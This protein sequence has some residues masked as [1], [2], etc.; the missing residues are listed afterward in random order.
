[1]HIVFPKT[2]FK[3]AIQNLDAA[4]NIYYSFD[5]EGPT[6][7]IQAGLEYETVNAAKH[8]YIEA[9][10]ASNFLV[11]VVTHNETYTVV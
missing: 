9:D 6:N 11:N 10:T 4:N 7:E 5:Q 2:T 8:L 3:T 1:M